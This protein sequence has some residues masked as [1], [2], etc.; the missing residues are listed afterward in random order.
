M[1]LNAPLKILRLV[2]VPFLPFRAHATSITVVGIILH[3]STL[4]LMN[5]RRK[6]LK[7]LGKL[8]TNFLQ[9]VFFTVLVL[10]VVDKI[11]PFFT[12]HKTEHRRR[13]ENH[14]V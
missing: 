12:L 9:D 10:H 8:R 6:A 3:Y 2:R 14:A 7:F 11:L 5:S 13:T 4:I 1:S